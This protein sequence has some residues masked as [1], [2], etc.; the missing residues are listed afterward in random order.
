[1]SA[2][3]VAWVPKNPGCFSHSNM[4]L[5]LAQPPLRPDQTSYP[6]RPLTVPTV[7]RLESRLPSSTEPHLPSYSSRL[8]PYSPECEPQTRWSRP[9][10]FLPHLRIDP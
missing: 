8:V 5:L 10:R 4:M 1:M 9:D 3:T 6:A 7:S 2:P